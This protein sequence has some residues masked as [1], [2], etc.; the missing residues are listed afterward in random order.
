MPANIKATILEIP[1]SLN[2]H[3]IPNIKKKIENISNESLEILFY[4]I[5]DH[6]DLLTEDEVLEFIEEEDLFRLD[7]ESKESLIRV[8]TSKKILFDS[9]EEIVIPILVGKVSSKEGRAIIKKVGNSNYIMSFLEEYSYTS[10]KDY[11]M[12]T[13]LKVSGVLS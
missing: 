5:E 2:I 4:G 1:K 9:I 12:L 7:P 13:A 3:K 6:V 8:Y 11:I 10:K